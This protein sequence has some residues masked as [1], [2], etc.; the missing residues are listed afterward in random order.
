MSLKSYT[1]AATW[2]RFKLHQNQIRMF[3][4]ISRLVWMFHRELD[5]KNPA[6]SIAITSVG[7]AVDAKNS[8]R[9]RRRRRLAYLILL[10][11]S[12]PPPR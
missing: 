7:S 12:H 11:Q 6:Q 5:S 10:M 2:H 3:Y 4:Q 9:R 1:E 8:P